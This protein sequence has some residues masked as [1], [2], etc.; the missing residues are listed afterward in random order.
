MITERD[1]V[2]ALRRAGT[3]VQFTTCVVQD[4]SPGF[5]DHECPC[6]YIHI[7]AN[8]DFYGA[9]L[10]HTLGI[11]EKFYLPIFA[12]SRVFGWSAHYMEQV[13]DNKIIRPQSEYTGPVGLEVP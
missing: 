7:P 9:L 13:S 12:A 10:M 11:E 5:P 1:H 8:L 6:C 4:F 3:H 2:F